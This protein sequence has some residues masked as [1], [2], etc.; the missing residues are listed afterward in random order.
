MNEKL[1]QFFIELTIKAEQE[2]YNKEGIKWEPIKYF[3]NKVVCDLIEGFLSFFFF[4]FISFSFFSL[5]S[6]IRNSNFIGK[7]PPG[8]F[9]VLDDVCQTMHAVGSEGA[10][11][12]K[13]LDKNAQVN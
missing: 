7:N 4:L 13:F 5:L 9:S 2:E 8:I 12:T 10:I 6:V 3:N 1:Q 11:D